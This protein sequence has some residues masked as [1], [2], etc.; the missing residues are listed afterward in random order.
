MTKEYDTK[1]EAVTG[2]SKNGLPYFRM[3]SG[4]RI[5]VIFGGG[6]DFAHKPPSGFQLRMESSSFK[7]LAKEYTVYCVSR[8]RGLPAGYSTRDMSNDY[9]VM[10]REEL[11]GPVDI[12]GLSSGGPIAHWFAVDHHDLIRHLILA[13]TGYRLSEEGK[14]W[15]RYM[16]DLA[17]QGKWRKAGVFMV[18]TIYPKGLKKH[19]FKLVMWLFGKNMIGVSDPSDG[20]VEVEAEVNHDFTSEQLAEIKVPTLVIGGEE[21]KFYLNRETAEGIPN[22]K[23]I[24]YKGFGHNAFDDNKHQ[25]QTDI[26]DFLKED[27]QFSKVK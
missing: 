27:S 13:E 6:P 4:Q 9:A 1:L 17:R 23:L 18:T 11:A 8:G 7:E 25:F 16:G 26:L 5:I 15:T 21:D 10:I 12:I 20:L 2:Y 24:L 14:E 22:A 3:G 19:L